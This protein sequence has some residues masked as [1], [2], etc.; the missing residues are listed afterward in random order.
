MFRSLTRTLAC[1]LILC[2]L[3]LAVLLPAPVVMAAPTL[4]AATPTPAPADPL[5]ELVNNLPTIKKLIAKIQQQIDAYESD[6]LLR[7]D[8][9]RAPLE[10]QTFF[11]RLQLTQRQSE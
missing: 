5:D 4:Q 11:S 7:L 10:L 2:Q 1:L 3:L 6:D 8:I 9:D